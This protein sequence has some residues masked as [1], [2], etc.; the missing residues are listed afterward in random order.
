MAILV[1]WRAVGGGVGL[2]Q[3]PLAS[4]LILPGQFE[5]SCKIAIRRYSLLRTSQSC[6][7]GI[8]GTFS[9][10][11]AG[12]ISPAA[13]VLQPF[14]AK[15]REVMGVAV[16]EAVDVVGM[17]L[18]QGLHKAMS[19]G[20][21]PPGRKQAKSGEKGSGSTNKDDAAAAVKK[22]SGQ[23]QMPARGIV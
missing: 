13:H 2:H 18:E 17:I 11:C 23:T 22:A 21:T 14:N 6:A 10:V 4:L 1:S 3:T 12:S 15:E 8:P 20:G 9:C 19:R 16:Q 5:V 7:A